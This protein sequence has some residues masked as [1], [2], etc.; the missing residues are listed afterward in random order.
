MFRI[1]RK[2]ADVSLRRTAKKM[3]ISHT[4]LSHL[5]RGKR[6]WN[7]GLQNRFNRVL[8]REQKRRGK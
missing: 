3:G 1:M 4:H 7:E 5:E 6:T 8:E 2:T